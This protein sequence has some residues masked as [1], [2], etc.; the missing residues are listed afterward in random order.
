MFLLILC[1]HRLC[2][3]SERKNF[4][5]HNVSINTGAW[6]IHIIVNEIFTFH[7]VSINTVGRA[8]LFTFFATLHSTMFLLIQTREAIQGVNYNTLHSTMFLLILHSNRDLRTE[9]RY[10]TF[11]NVSINTQRLSRKHRA[12]KSFTFHNVSINTSH[13]QSLETR[14]NNFTFHNVSI[15]TR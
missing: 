2:L 14:I 6:H 3:S 9:K 8:V 4:T 10:F 12:Q 5:F 7:N 1:K 13:K 15:N 11:H